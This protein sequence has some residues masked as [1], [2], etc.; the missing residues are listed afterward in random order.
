MS[1][2]VQ[3]K[4]AP[5]EELSHKVTN[6]EA[7]IAENEADKEKTDS[8]IQRLQEINNSMSLMFESEKEKARVESDSK[9]NAL[10]LEIAKLNTDL[11]KQKIQMSSASNTVE[12]IEDM[13][14]TVRVTEQ[15]FEEKVKH[16]LRL[17]TD[18][19]V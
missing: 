4:N 9:L 17:Q 1:D 11:S 15:R 12:S 8:R 10:K 19:E 7:Q 16:I 13:K 3:K 5:A 18:I 14:E 2:I 6:M